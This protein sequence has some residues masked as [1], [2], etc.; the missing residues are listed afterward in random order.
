MSGGQLSSTDDLG[1]NSFNIDLNKL[2]QNSHSQ[3]Q[4][5]IAELT[6]LKA[7]L[8]DRSDRLIAESGHWDS[9]KERLTYQRFVKDVVCFLL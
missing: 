6:A 9:D 2:I 1:H 7:Y 4:Q 5:R 8:A 3:S